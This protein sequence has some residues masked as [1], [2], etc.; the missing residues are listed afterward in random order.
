M[1]AQSL[2]TYRVSRLEAL[3]QREGGKAALGRRLGYKDGAFIGQMLRGDRPISEKTMQLVDSLPGCKGWFNGANQGHTAT[4]T[5]S[6][7]P[8]ALE[9]MADALR[10]AD[11][12]TIDQVRPLLARLVD[13]PE[14][15]AEIVPRLSALLE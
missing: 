5:T 14:R 8:E 10:R 4:E 15:A 13:S 2:Q 3:V 9:I 12:L 7:L 1:D 6:K 11:E